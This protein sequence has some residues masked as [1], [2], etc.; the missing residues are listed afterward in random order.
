MGSVLD[1]VWSI[2][3]YY[4]HMYVLDLEPLNFTCDE[5]QVEIVPSLE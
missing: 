4:K 5:V 3:V 1:F 2:T